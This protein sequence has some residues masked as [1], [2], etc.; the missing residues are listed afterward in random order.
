M[1]FNH[2]FKNQNCVAV[3]GNPQENQGLGTGP[4]HWYNRQFTEDALNWYDIE[5]RVPVVELI[6]DS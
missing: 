3:L 5:N 4:T 1:N 6:Y 2:S